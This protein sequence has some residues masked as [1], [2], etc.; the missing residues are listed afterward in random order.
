MKGGFG[1]RARRASTVKETPRCEA[2]VDGEGDTEAKEKEP[3]ALP[4]AGKG[5]NKKKKPRGG[6]GGKKGQR[7]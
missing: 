5:Q 7:R 4:H 2:S 3:I 6:S 1:G